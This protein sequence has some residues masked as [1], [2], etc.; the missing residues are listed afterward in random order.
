MKNEEYQYKNSPQSLTLSS[1]IRRVSEETNMPVN[2]VIKSLAKNCGVSERQIYNYRSGKT[3]IPIAV[4]SACCKRF[5]SSSLALSVLDQCEGMELPEAFDIVRL[6]NR[7]ARA[8][9]EAHCEFLQ[10]FNDGTICGAELTRLKEIKAKAISS[11]HSLEQVAE[12]AFLHNQKRQ[13]EV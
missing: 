12:Q 9:L 7:S 5:K 8:T 10:A 13:K 2:A 4:V 1:E 6:A 3:D 11:F